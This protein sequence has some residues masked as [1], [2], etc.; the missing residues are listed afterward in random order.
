M[1]NKNWLESM[2]CPGCGSEGPFE[3]AGRAWFRVSNDGSS[4]FTDLEWD[5]GSELHCPKCL[6]NGEVQDTLK[7]TPE[8][9]VIAIWNLLYLEDDGSINPNKDWSSAADMLAAVAAVVHRYKE[10]PKE[11]MS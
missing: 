3:I 9:C 2:K 5:D 11:V 1:P 10:A 4:E 8:A 6:W 7:W